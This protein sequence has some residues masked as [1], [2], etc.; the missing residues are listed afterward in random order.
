M[1]T[2]LKPDRE[3]TLA[4]ILL[5]CWRGVDLIQKTA[6]RTDLA[7]MLGCFLR[8]LAAAERLL[9]GAPPESVAEVHALKSKAAALQ[10]RI[11]PP[12]APADL[13]KEENLDRDSRPIRS[14]PA[15][16]PLHRLHRRGA[17]SGPRH[18]PA[19]R[20]RRGDEGGGEGGR[21]PSPE[22]VRELRRES[23]G[24]GPAAAPAPAGPGPSMKQT[25]PTAPLTLLDKLPEA[26]VW[27]EAGISLACAGKLAGHGRFKTSQP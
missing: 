15:R 19:L 22:P 27:V 12:I 13:G 21:S 2:R 1:K 26:R 11:G 18:A 16:R 5:C 23:P 4:S 7:V 8:D 17:S 9:P 3:N 24:S 6:S 10:R 20:P 25:K 14:A